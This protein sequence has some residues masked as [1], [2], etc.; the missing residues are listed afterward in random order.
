MLSLV[1]VESRRLFASNN[2]TPVL[3]I[4]RPRFDPAK[5]DSLMALVLFQGHFYAFSAPVV[6]RDKARRAGNG[7][8]LVK[9]RNAAAGH[10]RSALRVGLSAPL[11]VLRLLQ[12]T[13]PFGF[14]PRLA[15]NT[16]RPTECVNM[17]LKEH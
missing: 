9:R 13:G 6:F 11:A 4:P 7:R 3:A 17:T 15:R 1:F 5:S 8:A 16:D 12:R 10:P 14:K 2:R